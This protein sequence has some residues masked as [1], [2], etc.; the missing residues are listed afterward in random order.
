MHN[1]KFGLGQSFKVN[2]LKP[3]PGKFQFMILGINTDIKIDLFVDGNKLEK[4]HEVAL[5]GITIDD[6]LS[7]KTYIENIFE[8]QNTNYTR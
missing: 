5:L 6:K 1:L 8:Q 3:N 7:F 2:S 4:S